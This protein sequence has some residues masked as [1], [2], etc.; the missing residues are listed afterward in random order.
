GGELRRSRGPEKSGANVGRI[1][2]AGAGL[3]WGDHR[4]AWNRPGE[5]ALVAGGDERGR[6]RGAS[7]DQECARSGRDFESR[8]VFGL[9]VEIF[10]GRFC[11][12]PIAFAKEPASDTDALQGKVF[13]TPQRGVPTGR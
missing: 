10:V 3:G 9:V 2:S 13:R 12:T 5:E 6:P 4:R 8:E 1:V 11:E 7:R